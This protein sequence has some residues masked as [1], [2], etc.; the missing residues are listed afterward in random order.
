[1]LI[2]KRAPLADGTQIIDDLAKGNADWIK[3]MLTP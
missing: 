3:V 2:E 1:V